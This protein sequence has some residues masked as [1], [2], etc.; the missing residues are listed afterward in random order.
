VGVSAEGVAPVLHDLSLSATG[1]PGT[2]W[3]LDRDLD[4]DPSLLKDEK[5]LNSES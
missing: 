3:D 2:T 4:P 1:L 5:R